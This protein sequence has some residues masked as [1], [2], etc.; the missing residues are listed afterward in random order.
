MKFVWE[1]LTRQIGGIFLAKAFLII[2]TIAIFINII[3]ILVI[4]PSL[5]HHHHHH[6]RVGGPDELEH[7]SH[8]LPRPSLAAQ[9]PQL[10][11]F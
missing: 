5:P 10:P 7:A 6:G 4:M 9:H 2:I 1:V 11:A 3:I 8:H